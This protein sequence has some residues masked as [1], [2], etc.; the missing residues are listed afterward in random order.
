[1]AWPFKFLVA[2]KIA[3]GKTANKTGCAQR[4]EKTDPVTKSAENWFDKI[5]RCRI[6][7]STQ[8]KETAR[9]HQCPATS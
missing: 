9:G 6:C 3:P 8:S 1:M 2:D 5:A 7:R 4:G